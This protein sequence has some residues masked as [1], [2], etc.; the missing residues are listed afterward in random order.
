MV[1]STIDLGTNTLL[2]VTLSVGAD[3]SIRVLGDEHGIAR[4][5][6][7]VDATRTI[8]PEAFDRAATHLLRYRELAKELGSEWIVAFGTSALRDAA[9][10]QEFIDAME[11]RTG[12][13]ID[14]LS[15]SEEAELTYRGALF[16][17]RF[18]PHCQGVIDIGGGSTEIAVGNGQE[19]Q[20]SISIDIGAVRITERFFPTLPPTPEQIE[21]ARTFIRRELQLAFDLPPD[22]EMIGV[23]GTVTTL[24]AIAAGMSEFNPDELTGK[25]LA[26]EDI[27]EITRTLARMTTEEIV[28][29][30]G[31]HPDRADVLLGGSLVLD[32][33]MRYQDLPAITVSTRGVRYGVAMRE[34][35]RMGHHHRPGGHIA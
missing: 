15:G 16:G 9:N 17:F 3:G 5:G 33:F 12:I 18:G 25:R 19:L 35:E 20:R 29:M 21:E 34:M 24:G 23:A 11:Q 8:Q 2:M 32:E 6:R 13:H 1:F 4:L 7:G 30:R 27:T 22:V 31:V 26:D 10:R 28:H 14:L